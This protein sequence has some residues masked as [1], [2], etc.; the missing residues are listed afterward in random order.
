LY[1]SSR[2]SL[3]S[4]PL[5]TFWSYLYP[6]LS[7]YRQYNVLYCTVYLSWV[8]ICILTVYLS[9]LYPYLYLFFY[10]SPYSY[11]CSYLSPDCRLFLIPLLICTFALICIMSVRLSYRFL[12]LYL[13]SSV[14]CCPLVLSISLYVLLFLS[15]S[16]LSVC[17]IAILIWPLFLSVSCLSACFIAIL[18]CP[19]V[20]IC[21]L[22]VRLFYRYPYLAFVL[23]VSM[24]LSMVKS[25]PCLHLFHPSV[26]LS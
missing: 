7:H 25:R 12:Y 11:L 13:C 24:I 23:T 21:I 17:F 1:P 9:Y 4:T 3:I 2:K 15:V 16:C 6:I 8:L 20:P 14:F 22:S 19:F 10:L 18:I 26:P 5:S